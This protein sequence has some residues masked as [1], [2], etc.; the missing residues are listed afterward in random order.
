[1]TSLDEIITESKDVREVKRALSV[2]M[3][4]QGIPAAKISMILNVSL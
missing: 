4:Q 3:L 2:K 1:M